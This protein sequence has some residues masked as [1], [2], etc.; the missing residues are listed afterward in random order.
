MNIDDKKQNN[1]QAT[2]KIFSIHLKYDW[3]WPTTYRADQ[4]L[5][6]PRELNVSSKTQNEH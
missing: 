1:L 6:P 2:S 3:Y 4:P 5:D